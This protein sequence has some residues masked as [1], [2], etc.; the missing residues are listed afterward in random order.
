MSIRFKVI[1]PYLLLTLIV[2]VT[3]TYV[4]TRLVSSSLGERLSNQ[5]LEA[6]RV[7]SDTMARQEI[8]H[9]EAARIVAYTRGLG[10]AL[11]DG[12]V[13]QVTVLAKPAAGG[14]NVEN[15]LIFNAQGQEALH[16]IKQSNGTIMDVTQP[17][18][19]S[20][21]SI[22]DELLA[23]NDVNGLPRREMATDPVDG[24]Y[25][26]YTAIPAIS[27]D[28]M[29]GVVVVGTSFNTVLPLLKSTSLAD[30]II[31][32][33]DGQ[34]I[35][36]T[37]GPQETDSLFV[38]TISIPESVYQE[39][40]NLDD[41]VR[42]ENFQLDGRWYTLMRS[43]LKVGADRLA[44]L[45]VVL[46]MDFVVESNS[47]NRN[48]YVLLYSAAMIGVIFIGYFVAR[49][50]INPLSSLVRTSRAIA[51]GDLTRRTEIESQDEIGVLAS[52]FDEM[53][54]NL[55]ERTL[56]LE[57]TNQLLEQMD[58]TKMRFIQVAAHELRTPLTLVRGYAQ[59]A[60]FQSNGNENLASFT[61]SILDG[62]IR[63]GE[64]IDSMLDVSRIDS[65]LLEVM[66]S[67]VEL[68]PVIENVEKVFKSNLEERELCFKAEG[69]ADLPI[70][71]ADKDLLYKVFYHVVG[72]A[73]KY[74][75]DGG[76][77]IVSG[78]TV[79]DPVRGKEV[80]ISVKDTGIGIDPQY[81]ELVFE[82][83]YQ[84]GE[85]H[86]HSSG[87]TKFKGGG[88]GLGLA[89]ARGIINA[90]HGRIWINSPGHNEQMCPGTTVYVRLPLNGFIHES[91]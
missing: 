41:K 81:H 7:V 4:V 91:N 79:E 16:L 72:N 38:R 36:S 67:H 40:V 43:P 9:L 73:I 66:P 25:Y 45:A 29:A 85:V 88:P 52:T 20:T 49:L 23:G 87:K 15:L 54:S 78:R 71:H 27:K 12:D 30:I 62:S 61:S 48:N 37:L 68:G 22:V 8:K 3:G 46:P 77:I 39:V 58:R 86:L 31:Y 64:V 57:N 55:Q 70:L 76:R 51:K 83:F 34:A 74:T 69:L 14:L 63:M 21:L 42:G 35:A 53:T 5:L 11:D 84:T 10:D 1:L 47:V 89:I 32:G 56:Q 26:Y 60:K 2:A 65:N 28:R 6:G 50:I 17:D 18:Y 59:M 33:R 24:R 80:E 44:V 75:P 82:K 13:D 90:H 19:G